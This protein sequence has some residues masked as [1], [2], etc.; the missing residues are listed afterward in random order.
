MVAVGL[1]RGMLPRVD[2]AARVGASGALAIRIP[3]DYGN[4]SN[5]TT[6]GWGVVLVVTWPGGVLA[7]GPG[8]VPPPGRLTP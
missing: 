5:Y 2:E 1:K 8:G 7:H 6:L 4:K 3:E